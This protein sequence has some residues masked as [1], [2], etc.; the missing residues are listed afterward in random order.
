LDFGSKA[1]TDTL[2]K[3][4]EFL[5]NMRGVW[6]RSKEVALVEKRHAELQTN[7][8]ESLR[9]QLK[10]NR[11]TEVVEQEQLQLSGNT[12]QTDRDVHHRLQKGSVAFFDFLLEHF[13]TSS[14][15]PRARAFREFGSIFAVEFVALAQQGRGPSKTLLN[16]VR[17]TGFDP[18]RQ[19]NTLRNIKKLHG[20]A[21][22]F[23][24]AFDS[25]EE[26]NIGRER[27]TEIAEKLS[28]ELGGLSRCE[29][30]RPHRHSVSP[31]GKAIITP[32]TALTAIQF[33]QT[34]LAWLTKFFEICVDHFES[35]SASGI[36]S[37]PLPSRLAYF[38]G[39]HPDFEIDA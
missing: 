9:D 26:E 39:E 37:A 36:L 18:S 4:F 34:K 3:L 23:R 21:R 16:K 31:S 38:S 5:D 8:L 13:S 11:N 29:C 19:P 12:E 30:G 35:V 33:E 22:N 20:M 27:W 17:D 24:D 25:V 14:K 15:T 1:Q 2:K 6:W 10:L 28:D 7:I 32:G